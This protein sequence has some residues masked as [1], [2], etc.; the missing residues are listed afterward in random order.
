MIDASLE[1]FTN[2]MS[3]PKPKRHIKAYEK[4]SLKVIELVKNGF[5]ISAKIRTL[6]ASGFPE[7]FDGF[8]FFQLLP[9]SEAFSRW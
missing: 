2:L 7:A 3:K 8:S 5:A 1:F 4:T 9:D 6:S